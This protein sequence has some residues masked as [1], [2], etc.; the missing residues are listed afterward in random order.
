MRLVACLT[1]PAPR[2]PPPASP[3]R[4]LSLCLPLACARRGEARDDGGRAMSSVAPA[5]D[6]AARAAVD[7]DDPA[8]LREALPGL[9]AYDTR[10]LLLY[11]RSR[12]AVDVLLEAGADPDAV[13]VLAFERRCHALA[14][15][16]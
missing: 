6:A 11:A 4:R 15:R 1:A 9:D 16:A 13:R 12:A 8:A 14:A 5:R 10:R 3:A 7:A 2:K